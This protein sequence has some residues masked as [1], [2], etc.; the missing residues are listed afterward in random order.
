MGQVQGQAAA[1]EDEKNPSSANSSLDSLIAG[2]ILLLST[3]IS[4]ARLSSLP[5]KAVQWFE[6]MPSFGCE[7]DEVTYS[8]MID[9]Y[10]KAGNVN[11][12]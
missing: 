11:M 12:V 2:P 8:V 5:E 3:I 4:C 10:G 7:P 1:P 9:A 6:K